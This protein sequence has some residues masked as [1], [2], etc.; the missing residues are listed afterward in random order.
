[1]KSWLL[2]HGLPRPEREAQEGEAHMRIASVRLLSL[3]YTIFDFSGCIVNPQSANRARDGSHHVLR[4]LSAAA[5][6]HRVICVA[7]ERTVGLVRCIQ[8][9]KA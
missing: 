2:A 3:Q 5:V 8:T 4:L 6:N 1:M 9:S 7:G